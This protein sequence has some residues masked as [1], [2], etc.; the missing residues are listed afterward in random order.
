VPHEKIEAQF[1]V[2]GTPSG[3]AN[4][5][6]AESLGAGLRLLREDGPGC[7]KVHQG[8]VKRVELA[9]L[10]LI[11]Q[12]SSFRLNYDRDMLLAESFKMLRDF[13]TFD[14]SDMTRPLEFGW[15]AIM[16]Y[17]RHHEYSDLV[18]AII[19]YANNWRLM[20]REDVS[21]MM[22]HQA[23]HIA[24]DRF[25]FDDRKN[26]PMLQNAVSWNV[27]YWADRYRSGNELDKDLRLLSNLAADAATPEAEVYAH[28]CLAGYWIWEG[29][30]GRQKPCK[31]SLDKALNQAEKI[32]DMRALYHFPQY[33]TSILVR[34]KIEALLS[35]RAPAE[36]KE[37]ARLIETEY[38]RFS[39]VD[40]HLYS[41]R[42]LEKWAT[43]RELNLSFRLCEPKYAS[44]D[45][46]FLPRKKIAA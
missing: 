32:D 15:A 38:L 7:T 28:K 22:M 31:A 46:T 18:P 44:A 23:W 16:I 13:G 4:A 8:M 35:T 17:L 5:K 27:R 10:A 25:K 19:A 14:P 6:I 9:S 39:N 37:A 12:E 40:R 41:F 26:A 20:N 36:L 29:T 21:A 1:G 3:V 42:T 43:I 24:H 45:L 30:F 2:F 11:N 34:P 33:V